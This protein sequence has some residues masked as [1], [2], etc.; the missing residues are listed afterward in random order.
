MVHRLSTEL[1]SL[2]ACMRLSVCSHVHVHTLR[3][4][5]SLCAQGMLI[6]RLSRS[7]APMDIQGSSAGGLDTQPGTDMRYSLGSGA[8]T[9]AVARSTSPK[10]SRH[11]WHAQSMLGSYS[12]VVTAPVWCSEAM[13]SRLMCS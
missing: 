6:E 3:L 4:T 13:P 1:L 8:Y 11:S 12:L 2:T 10:V 7:M 5:L 9:A